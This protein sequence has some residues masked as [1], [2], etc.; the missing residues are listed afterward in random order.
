[1][2]RTLPQHGGTD[3]SWGGRR[4]V[5][6]FMARI[7]FIP[8]LLTLLAMLVFGVQAGAVAAA[9]KVDLEKAAK[10]KAA[11]LLNLAKFVTWPESA[12]ADAKAPLVIGVVGEDPFGDVLEQTVKDKTVSKRAIE[13]RRVATLPAKKESAWS[14]TISSLQSCH[15][16][17]MGKLDDA[18]V[19]ELLA[20]LATK[21][22]LTVGET[23]AF[24]E[25]RGMV[26]FDLDNGKISIHVNQKKIE[27]VA[28]RMSANLLKLVKTVQPR[29]GGQEASK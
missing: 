23:S 12:F 10:V 24:A 20:E 25:S 22:V 29:S 1:M 5:R 7:P 8:I 3:V 6:H 17:Y 4:S 13:I 14:S 2:I 18:R 26:G 28:M 16:L 21:P 27:D 9:E 11:C 19:D 15:I